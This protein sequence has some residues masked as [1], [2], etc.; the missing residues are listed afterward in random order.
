[1]GI[2]VVSGASALALALAGSPALSTETVA[3]TYLLAMRIYDGDRLVGSPKV[4][5]AADQPS[6][7]EI[8]EASG[9]HYNVTVI[10][11]ARTGETILIRSKIDIVSGGFH[12]ALSPDMLVA[13]NK[14]S[15]V[16]FGDES[17]SFKPIRVEFAINKVG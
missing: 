16:A 13:L 6:T 1:M 8:T 14:P 15:S 7:I 11:T 2:A 9:N 17:V 12:Q 3:P 10:A 4:T 5:V